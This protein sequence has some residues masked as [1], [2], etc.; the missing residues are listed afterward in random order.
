MPRA[1]VIHIEDVVIAVVQDDLRDS[2]AY[3]LQIDLSTELERTHATGVIVDLSVVET[4]DSFL[5][6]LI[7]DIASTTQLLGAQTVVV[8]IQPSIAITLTELGLEL[9]DVRTALNI[10]KGLAILRQL[11]AREKSMLRARGSFLDER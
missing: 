8:G 9:H 1:P 6:R 10:E 4:I 3:Q 5:G 2:D 7:A 11:Q